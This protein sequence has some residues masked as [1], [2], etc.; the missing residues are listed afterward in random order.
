[1][2]LWIFGNTGYVLAIA[3]RD[4]SRARNLS[5]IRIFIARIITEAI[6]INHQCNGSGLVDPQ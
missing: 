4:K 2:F 1:M 3:L 5:F 6:Q